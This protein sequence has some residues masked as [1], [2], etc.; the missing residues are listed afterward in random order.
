MALLKPLQVT[1]IHAM[2]AKGPGNRGEGIDGRAVRIQDHQF[3]VTEHRFAITA[4][5]GGQL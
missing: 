5:N 2:T 3:L 4:V 1:D